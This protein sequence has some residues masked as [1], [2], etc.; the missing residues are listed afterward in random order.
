[1]INLSFFLTLLGINQSFYFLK[2]GLFFLIGLFNFRVLSKELNILFLFI[3][4]FC[5]IIQN[6]HSAFFQFNIRNFH[7]YP[8]F[9]IVIFPFLLSQISFNLTLTKKFNII[10][11]SRIFVLLTLI[12]ILL[13]VF[14]PQ[15][16]YFLYKEN[17]LEYPRLYKEIGRT[18]YKGVLAQPGI[19]SSEF[20]MSAYM[21][22][23]VP[24]SIGE[25]LKPFIV[26]SYRYFLT[27]MSVVISLVS[28]SRGLF[29]A[30]LLG[31]SRS[32]FYIIL[33]IIVPGL[34]VFYLQGVQLF[35]SLGLVNFTSGDFQ[36]YTYF[37]EG[38]DL[39]LNKPLGESNLKTFGDIYNTWPHNFIIIFLLVYGID[40]LIVL[41]YF[42]IILKKLNIYIILAILG[43][44]M[45][46]IFHNMSPFFLNWP[47]WVILGYGLAE[48][49]LIKEKN[50]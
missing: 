49:K 26:I 27:I 31:L 43:G 35:K 23:L 40:F 48:R 25:K 10:L 34:I 2:F 21:S 42:Y 8:L 50:Y 11:V 7:A 1:M 19:S 4:I 30:L 24:L 37:Y 47:F 18:G 41:L 14:V 17:I 36:R 39:F 45:S 22:M 16:G 29:L 28:T 46:A 33:I 6:S 20:Y 32:K 44:F 15:L 12:F 5:V 13:Q 9:E 38:I 3:I